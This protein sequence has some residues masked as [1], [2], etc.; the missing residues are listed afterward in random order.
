MF[1]ELKKQI[2]LNLVD[3]LLLK[4]QQDNEVDSITIQI[5]YED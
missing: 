2:S 1:R 4:S 5:L 3:K